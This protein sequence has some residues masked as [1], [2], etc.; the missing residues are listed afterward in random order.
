MAF[1][2]VH[3]VNIFNCY[4]VSFFILFF[5]PRIGIAPIVTASMVMQLMAGNS[6]I[7]VNHS[8]KEDRALFSGAQKVSRGEMDYDCVRWYRKYWF[9]R[10]R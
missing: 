10:L 2:L 4:Y 8:S 3:H 9:D 7:E 1:W 6:Q 5:L